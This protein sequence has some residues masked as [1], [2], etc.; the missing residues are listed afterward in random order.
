M[1]LIRFVSW[2]T[3]TTTMM[4]SMCF[5]TINHYENAQ[6]KKNE[7]QKNCT[8][9]EQPKTPFENLILVRRE[10]ASE[11]KL[12]DGKRRTMYHMHRNRFHSLWHCT[13]TSRPF[14]LDVDYMN[15]TEKKNTFNSRERKKRAAM[16]PECM[17][18]KHI[19][20]AHTS[21]SS[22]ETNV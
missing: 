7:L 17:N 12:S 4:S 21:L 19:W 3:T 10:M 15:I 1:E 16:A 13:F 18:S 5:I 6:E 8:E 20:K 9:R 11:E 22:T 2:S 14:C